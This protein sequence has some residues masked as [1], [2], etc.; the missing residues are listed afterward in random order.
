M[1]AGTEPYLVVVGTMYPGRV[2]L[3]DHARLFEAAGCGTAVRPSSA[4]L[5]LRC[6]PY[7]TRY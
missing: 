2:P 3:L 1:P 5:F 7:V 6:S 4:L